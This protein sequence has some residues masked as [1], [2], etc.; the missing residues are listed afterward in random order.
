MLIK[1]HNRKEMLNL[2]LKKI[3][4]NLRVREGNKGEK[5][6]NKTPV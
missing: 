6:L 4:K 2:E 3:I 5:Y 1:L